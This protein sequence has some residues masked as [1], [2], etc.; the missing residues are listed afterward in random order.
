MSDDIQKDIYKSLSEI[1]RLHFLRCHN[2][3]E[4]FNIYPGQ[5]GVLC[6]L[7]KKDGQSQKEL[8][9][10]LHIRP[11]TLTVMLKR[12]EKK[13]LIKRKQDENDKRVS[14]IYLCKAGLDVVDDIKDIHI[15]IEKKCFKN[16]SDEEK[17][18]LRRL[19]FQ[20]RDNLKEDCKDDF[21]KGKLPICIEEENL[22]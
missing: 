7:K 21:E 13:G 14:R 5:S 18:I 2:H 3:L 12:M 4:K 1:M 10:A 20:I 17:I 9:D 19:L 22:E 11:A 6:Y 16:I 8:C 15:D